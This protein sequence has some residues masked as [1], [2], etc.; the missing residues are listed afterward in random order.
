MAA[1]AVAS[2]LDESTQRT[3][4]QLQQ[5]GA[6]VPPAIADWLGRLAL[7]YGVPFE[8]L[9]PD[10]RMLPS[11]SIRFFYIDENWIQSLVDGAFSV[12]VHSKL[13]IRFHDVLQGAVR[14]ATLEAAGRLRSDLRGEK[15]PAEASANTRCGFLLRSVAVSGWPGLEVRALKTVGGAEVV[16]LLRMD[17][18]APDILLCIVAGIPAQIEIWEPSEDLHFGVV[19]DLSRAMKLPVRDPQTGKRLSTG[20]SVPVSFRDPSRRTLNMAAMA[21]SLRSKTN[22]LSGGRTFGSAD[23]SVQMIQTAEKGIFTA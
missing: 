9:V 19:T 17:R 23:F 3:V 2:R 11:D 8:N 18:L 22:Q 4:D 16:P 13:D 21:S 15:T 12:G 20:D 6:T 5:L 1:S 10:V 14:Q 7:L